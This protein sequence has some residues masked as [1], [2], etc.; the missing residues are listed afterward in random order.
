VV[1]SSIV[2][3]DLGSYGGICTS[4][5]HVIIGPMAYKLALPSHSKLHLVFH[6]SCLRK[7]IET[8]CKTHNSLP[9]LDEESSIW[10]HPQVVLDHR[11]CRLF[12]HTILAH[13]KDTQPED[14][15]WEPT[16]ILQQFPHLKP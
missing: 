15:T 1:D 4:I 16:S 6:I 14:A 13:W 12:Q 9:K 5:K 10:L 2:T 8:K 11:E 3:Q 7:A